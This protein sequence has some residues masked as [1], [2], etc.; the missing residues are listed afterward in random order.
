MPKGVQRGLACPTKDPHRLYLKGHAGILDFPAD[1]HQQIRYR[2]RGGLR[3]GA[4]WR[5]IYTE[6]VRA[7]LY[8]DTKIE[9]KHLKTAKKETFSEKF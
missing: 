6:S 7:F 9:E 1:A 8:K 3:G 4:R 5:R 2:A